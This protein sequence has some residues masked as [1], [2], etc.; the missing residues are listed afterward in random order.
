MSHLRLDDIACSSVMVGPC[1]E[2]WQRFAREVTAAEKA[3]MAAEKGFA[4][5]FVEGVLVKAVRQGWWLLL[6]E[7][8]LA[9]AEVRSS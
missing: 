7:I 4:F 2:A 5:A 6:D 8:N 3:S 1:R 9:P